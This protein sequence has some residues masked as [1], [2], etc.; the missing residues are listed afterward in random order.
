[1]IK[2][3]LGPN[4]KEGASIP[5]VLLILSSNEILRKHLAS[6]LQS[7]R[8]RLDEAVS[9]AE[10]PDKAE[11]EQP[12]IV[13]HEILHLLVGAGEPMHCG[14][15]AFYPADPG[16]AAIIDRRPGYTGATRPDLRVPWPFLS[17][18][19]SGAVSSGYRR[20]CS[21]RNPS[22]NPR[23][24]HRNSAVQKNSLFPV[25]GTS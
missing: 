16:V 15:P 1:M 13:L 22:A 7:R 20:T 10:A 9:G 17:A 14:D 3:R 4:A 24:C 11:A 12:A 6:Q 5:T 8:W 25:R 19:N 2:V 23:T 18:Q 21:N